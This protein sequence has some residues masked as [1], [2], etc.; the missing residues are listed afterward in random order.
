MLALPEKRHTFLN[1][2][3]LHDAGGSARRLGALS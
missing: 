3:D 1:T 2:Q